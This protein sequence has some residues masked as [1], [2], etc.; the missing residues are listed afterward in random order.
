MNLSP[1]EWYRLAEIAEERGGVPAGF[2]PT[3]TRR[4]ADT[5]LIHITGRVEI[6]QR[7]I[8]AGTAKITDAGKLLL[9]EKP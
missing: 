2:M 6:E 8:F 7:V 3:A 9:R 4:L 5:G 1:V